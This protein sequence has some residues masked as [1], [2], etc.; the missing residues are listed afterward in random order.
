M[1]TEYRLDTAASATIDVNGNGRHTNIG[2]TMPGERWMIEILG[3]N[4]PARSKLYV[5]RGNSFDLSR[6]L[7]YTSRADGDTSAANI[8]LLAGEHISFFWIGGTT[9]SFMRCSI[10]G[11]RFVPGQRAY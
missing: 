2:P 5:I 1:E 10:S 3:A 4:G 6:Q 7:D 8:T 11:K 9:G